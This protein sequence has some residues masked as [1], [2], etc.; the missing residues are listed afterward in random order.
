MNWLNQPW[1]GGPL[2]AGCSCIRLTRRHIH[3]MLLVIA[4]AQDCLAQTQSCLHSINALS[5][6]GVAA[7]EAREQA[8]MLI[9]R[10]QRD[11]DALRLLRERLNAGNM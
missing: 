7:D 5:W 8:Q 1:Q 4:S 11:W 3:L 9:L 10:A 2:I 6:D